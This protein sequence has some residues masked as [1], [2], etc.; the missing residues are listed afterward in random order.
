M[1]VVKEEMARVN[2]DILEIHELNWTGKGKFNSDDHYIYFCGQESLRRNGAD[3]RGKK[4]KK[5]TTQN[6]PKCIAWVQPQNR[7]NYLGSFPR[8]INQHHNDPSNAPTNNAKESGVDWFYED[9]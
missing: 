7:Q 9:L 3:F 6:S 5:K 4:K 8:Q 1:E 2:I